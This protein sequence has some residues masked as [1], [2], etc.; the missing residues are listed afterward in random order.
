MIDA[1]TGTGILAIMAEKMGAVSVLG[2]DN[3][4]WCIE[5][6]QENYGLNQCS[7]CSV[8][9]ASSMTGIPGEPVDTIVANINKNVILKELPLYASR[10]NE[11]GRLFLSGFYTEDVSDIEVLAFQHGLQ[12]VDSS[13][14]DNWAC[15]V[16]QKTVTD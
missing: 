7:R 3:D 2:F 1:G 4:P 13:A 16:Y 5:N 12:P 15:L 11:G 10:L 6:A 8:V 14:H 9:L